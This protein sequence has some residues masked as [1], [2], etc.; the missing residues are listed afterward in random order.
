MKVS[1]IWKLQYDDQ[2]ASN[3]SP[4]ASEEH[5]QVDSMTKYAHLTNT[6]T[7]AFTGLMY[8]DASNKFLSA[9]FFYYSIKAER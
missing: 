2:S 8:D 1:A 9:V 3:D 5:A 7:A 4:F 6:N